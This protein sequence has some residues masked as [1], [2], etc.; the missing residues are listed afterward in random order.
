[1]LASLL[2]GHPNPGPALAVGHCSHCGASTAACAPRRFRGPAAGCDHGRM[3][4]PPTTTAAEDRRAGRGPAP[5]I[6]LAAARLSDAQDGGL[7][8]RDRFELPDGT[9]Y[10]D[11]N[12]LGPLPR[13]VQ[14]A[15]D[16]A[17]APAVGPGPDHVLE[18][19]RLVGAA[20]PGGRPARRPDGR[21]RRA[22]DLRGLHLGTAVPALVAACRLRPGRS[23]LL[24]DGDELSHRPVPGRFG[25]PAARPAG[26][27]AAPVGAG[28]HLGRRGERVAAVSFSLVDY[29]TGELFDA[30]ELTRTV[31]AP[32]R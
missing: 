26:G 5:R 10:L 31:Q 25:G 17:G 23:V 7:P 24:T 22:G 13:A 3:T 19:P 6:L 2:A 32:A 11:G 20:P 12:S 4:N 15:V 8:L 16:G 30:A 9:V 27:P 1:M 28:R 14:P 21:R 18:R 29:R